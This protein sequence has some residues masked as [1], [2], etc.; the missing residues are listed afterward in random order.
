MKFRVG[1][2]ITLRFWL[3]F[4]GGISVFLYLN[5]II[6]VFTILGLVAESIFLGGALYYMY[7]VDKILLYKGVTNYNG[8]FGSE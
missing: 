7:V 6:F 4:Q 1:D 2:G 5:I 8:K 3:S